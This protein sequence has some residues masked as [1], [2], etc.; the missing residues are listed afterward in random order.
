MS[1]RNR[2]QEYEQ[3]LRRYE[4]AVKIA[5]QAKIAVDTERAKLDEYRAEFARF[6]ASTLEEAVV[7]RAQQAEQI[8]AGMKFLS[9]ALSRFDQ[10]VAAPPPVTPPPASPPKPTGSKPSLDDLLRL[11]SR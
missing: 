6:G 3:L 10:V 11:G 4:A 1:E 8:D 2:Q 5:Y 9:D 7:L